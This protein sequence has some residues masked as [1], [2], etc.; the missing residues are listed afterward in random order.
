MN[1]YPRTGCASV[2]AFSTE[3]AK[4]FFELLW[5]K[6]DDYLVSDDQRGR[7][8]AVIGADQFE[9]GFLVRAH[10]A[11]FKLESSIH[12]EGLQDL[13]WRSA[14]LH[15]QDHL[16]KR[17]QAVLRGERLCVNKD[18]DSHSDDARFFA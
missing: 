11:L 3:L 10:V 13:A 17:H 14:G 7:R 6:P 4:L 12:E 5:V 15:E 8:S 1:R 18:A 2:D 9:N 16:R